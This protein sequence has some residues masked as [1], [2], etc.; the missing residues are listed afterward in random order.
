MNRYVVSTDPT[1]TMNITG[2]RIIVRGFS[3]LNESNDADLTIAGSK[4]DFEPVPWYV[5]SEHGARGRVA[6]LQS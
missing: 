5:P 3:F 1:S 4:I 2:L 6:V